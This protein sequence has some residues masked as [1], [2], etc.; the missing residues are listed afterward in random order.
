MSAPVTR[1]TPKVVERLSVSQVDDLVRSHPL[2]DQR[3]CRVLERDR[4]AGVRRIAVRAREQMRRRESECARVRRMREFETR[5]WRSGVQVVAGVDEVGRG[6]LAGPVVAAAVAFPPGVELREIDDSKKLPPEVR[7]TLFQQI[8]EQAECVAVVSVGVPEIDELNI[9]QASLKA[10]RKALQELAP[11][12]ERVLV[13]GA[14][15]PGSPFPETAIVGGDQRSVSIA[16]A[17][18]VAKVH[19]D[20]MMVDLDS[21]YP[22]YGFASNKGYASAGHRQALKKYGPCP[23][24]R[25]SFE[26]VAEQLRPAPS[27]ALRRCRE[28]LE[29]LTSSEDLERWL[30]SGKKAVPLSEDEERQFGVSVRERRRRLRDIGARGEQLAAAH[31]VAAGYRVIE[32]NY[33]GAGAEIDIVARAAKCLVF[34]EVKASESRLYPPELRVAAEK[35]ERVT[36]AARYFIRR[37]GIPRG[38]EVRFDVL[39]VQLGTGSG[40]PEVTHVEDAFQSSPFFSL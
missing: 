29:A 38:C 2:I 7:E 6:C 17:A 28:K 13:D 9:L 5:L 18:I 39:A 3:A 35:Q 22:Q 14:L 36:R 30:R 16:A 25:R 20:R 32:R 21:R 1:I 23:Q 31:L 4:R 37:R 24:H 15:K 11:P 34:V 19:R 27:R 26:P 40:G 33:R 8:L 10:M 12:P